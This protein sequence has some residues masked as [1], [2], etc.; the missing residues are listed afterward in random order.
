MSASHG[1]L[2][3][4]RESGV[5]S[6]VAVACLVDGQ[7]GDPV[8]VMFYIPMT[9]VWGSG[10]LLAHLSGFTID[11]RIWRFWKGEMEY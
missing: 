5:T 3:P 7:S 10:I 1:L 11:I 2:L 6:S 8:R 9:S 4:L